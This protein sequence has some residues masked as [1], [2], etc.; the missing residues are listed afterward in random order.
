MG[1]THN[2]TVRQRNKRINKR[3]NNKL[4]ETGD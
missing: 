4:M 2:A 1:Q 3:M